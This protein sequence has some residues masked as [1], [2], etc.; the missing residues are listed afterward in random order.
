MSSRRY[1]LKKHVK[2][3]TEPEDLSKRKRSL[4]RMD[5]ATGNRQERALSL[6]DSGKEE[7]GPEGWEH[8]ILIQ[9]LSPLGTVPK[10]SATL[11]RYN[12]RGYELN[13]VLCHVLK[14]Q[15]WETE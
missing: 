1:T 15:K 7:Q 10:T 14:L 3:K 4:L 6:S 2:E 8:E 13:C 11:F 9:F 5:R 12:Q